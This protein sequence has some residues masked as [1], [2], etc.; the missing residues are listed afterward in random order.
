MELPGMDNKAMN[1]FNRTK[2][3]EN[4]LPVITNLE[5]RISCE[6]LRSGDMS[7]YDETITKYTL[8]DGQ[9]NLFISLYKKLVP[10]QDDYDEFTK[11]YIATYNLFPHPDSPNYS[12]SN[13]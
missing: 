2:I 8:I 1:L 13:I 7:A 6:R 9:K 12:S 4:G 5:F 10:E 11:N 3:E